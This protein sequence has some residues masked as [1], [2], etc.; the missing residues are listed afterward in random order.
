MEFDKDN[1]VIQDKEYKAILV[2]A[3]TGED[4]AYSMEELA[5]L[6]GAAGIEVLACMV[7]NVDKI[8]AATFIGSG[9]LVEL[10]EMCSN[11]EAE[12]VIFNDEL[13][14]MQLRNIEDAVGVRVIDRTIL[15]LDIFADRAISA[16]GKLQVELAQLQYR[17]PRLLG[18]GK[19]LSRLGGG[20]GTRGPGE[21]KL[22]TD[23]RHIQSR[24]D[25]IKK[26]LEALKANR[27][28]QRAKREKSGLPVVALVGYTNS[29]KSSIMN[30]LL[31]DEERT[32]KQVFEKDM[33]F[34]T[35][36]TSQRLITLDDNRSFIL[37]DTVG[38][39]DKLPHTLVKAFKATLEELSLADMLIHVVDAGFG[40]PDFHIDVTRKVMKELD[41]SDKPELLVFNKIDLNPDFNA[42]AYSGCI[43]T[44]AKTGQGIDVLLEKIK[45]QI[46]SD[47]V[48]VE[49]LIPFNRGDVVSAVMAK[50]KPKE[51]KYLE[52]GTYLKVDLNAE[53]RGRWQSFIQQ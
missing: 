8:N 7:Q 29:G 46:F 18:F 10:S 4:I 3:T 33:L 45:A 39:V 53:D 2:G 47:I 6:A 28:V 21:K 41:A 26:E 48:E 16:D 42:L 52:N 22:E 49:L 12:L 5:G 34:A 43:T 13:S 44:S 17:M 35:L 11:M 15:I 14:G 30:K 23:R 38:F 24:M 9:K 19:S 36:D 37:I 50:A 1:N 27:S 51:T 40:E 20:I 25:E 31:A 32:E